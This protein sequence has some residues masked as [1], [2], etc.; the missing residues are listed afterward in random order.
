MKF[1][2]FINPFFPSTKVR[3]KFVSERYVVEGLSIGLCRALKNIHTHRCGG[4]GACVTAPYVPEFLGKVFVFVIVF[5]VR[6]VFLRLFFVSSLAGVY[7][8]PGVN[9]FVPVTKFWF[10]ARFSVTSIIRKMIFG[11][12]TM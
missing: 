9:F 12:V 5:M 11:S 7:F 1:D 8:R 2:N 6:T 10:S 3:S 4:G